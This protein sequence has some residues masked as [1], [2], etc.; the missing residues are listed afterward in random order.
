VVAAEEFDGAVS[1]WAQKLAGKSPVIMRLGKEAMRRQLDMPLDDA[2]DY[3]RS[4]LT[5]A[6]ST[7]DIVEGVTAFFE[8][9]DPQWKGR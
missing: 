1:E 3:L 4:Q 5:L 8:K 9:R 2:L 7:E 6:L